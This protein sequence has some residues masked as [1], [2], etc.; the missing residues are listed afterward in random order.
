MICIELYKE[1]RKM[2][3]TSRKNHCI[4][5]CVEKNCHYPIRFG[6]KKIFFSQYAKKS[7]CFKNHGFFESKIISFVRW[8]GKV[9]IFQLKFCQT[10]LISSFN[11]ATLIFHNS[12]NL[13]WETLKSCYDKWK[14]KFCLTDYFYTRCVHHFHT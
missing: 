11:H 8:R 7:D 4:L 12:K 2:M 10:K 14:H 13:E 6:S 5:L 1:V 9:C 3:L